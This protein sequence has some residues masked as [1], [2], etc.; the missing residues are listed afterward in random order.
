MS[1]VRLGVAPIVLSALLVVAG[2]TYSE[3]EPG[4][5]ERETPQP[6]VG[7]PSSTSPPTASPLPVTNPELPVAGE[8]VWTSADGLDVQVR[9]AVHAVRR[10]DGGTVL[11][12]SVTPIR[13]ANRRPGDAGA[14]LRSTSACPAGGESSANVLLVDAPGQDGLPAA[15]RAVRTPTTACVRRSGCRSAA[16]ASASP[17]CCRLPSPSC[18]MPCARSMWTSRPCPSSGGSPSPRWARSRSPSRPTDLTRPAEVSA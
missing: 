13:A 18:R 14:R 5:L 8:S 1:T 7:P 16:S 15:G 12:W 6:S 9:F 3:Q 4:L 17:R 2:C 10:V 11:D